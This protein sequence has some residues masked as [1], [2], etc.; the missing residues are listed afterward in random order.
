MA[1]VCVGTFYRHVQNVGQIN[2][3]KLNYIAQLMITR[4]I[5]LNNC[6][7]YN[8]LSTRRHN[9]GVWPR[10]KKNST[11]CYLDDCTKSLQKI[12]I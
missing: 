2:I 1:R 10:H 8:L 9:S 6:G 12:N 3:R 7:L 4:I 5:I 11:K